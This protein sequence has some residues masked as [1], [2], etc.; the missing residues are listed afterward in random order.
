MTIQEKTV[1]SVRIL[2]AEMI[3]NAGSGHHGI[4]MGAAPVGYELYAEIM[5][6][7]PACP[8][9]E[10]RDRFVLSAGHGSAMLYSLL[11]L[12][13][14]GLDESDLKSFRKLG[15]KT[16]GH[17]ERGVTPGVD[18]STG[19]L[20][21]GVACAVGFAMAEAY[22]AAKF[23]RNGFNVVDHYTYAL[24]G[25]GCLEEG[26]GYEA[27]SFAGTQKLGKLILFYDCNKISIEGDTDAA[28][29]EDIPARFRSQGWQVLNVDDICDLAAIRAAAEEAKRDNDRPSLIIC[30]S[31]IGRGT[32]AEGTAEAHGTP[33]TA[34]Q[35]A[36]TKA[37]YGWTE[38]PFK[39][40]SAVRAYCAQCVKERSAKH[41]AWEKM[42]A[43][44]SRWHPKLATKYNDFMCGN[45]SLSD[46]IFSE[47][48]TDKP[49]ATR[50]SG[51]KVINALKRRFNVLRRAVRAPIP[52]I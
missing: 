4:C 20:G 21:Q 37:H 16:P 3:T 33:L 6:Y 17:P 36:R 41:A 52:R 32:P 24:C 2:S 39:V 9:W 5:N 8:D 47:L 1:D 38:E 19:A 15:S 12:F 51:G 11:Y 23:N 45:L 42:F 30:R 50:V 40:P 10:N 31:V 48:A 7:D 27:C 13:G 22:L 34:D 49:E 14:F 35:L 44:Y 26:I 43:E 46:D 29:N 28:F 25:E 18:C